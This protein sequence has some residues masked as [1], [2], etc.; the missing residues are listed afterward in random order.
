MNYTLPVIKT[1]LNSLLKTDIPPDSI[2]CCI[3]DS[4]SLEQKCSISEMLSVL[5]TDEYER[6]DSITNAAAK[7]RFILGRS[8]IRYALAYY[9]NK[10][11]QDIIFRYNAHGKPYQ[12]HDR[13][14]AFNLSH[15]ADQFALAISLIGE[16]GVDIEKHK[17]KRNI[18]GIANEILT[19][20]ELQW[21]NR[22]SKQEQAIQFYRLWSLKEATLKA[23]GVGLGVS[24]NSF[25]FG[26]SMA[27]CNWNHLFGSLALWRW[28]YLPENGFSI[29]VALKKAN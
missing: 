20:D 25:G 14:I 9:L 8:L 11:A 26:K 12:N 4:A 6:L 18:Q 5:S 16:V 10:P 21:F 15:T 19:A 7:K 29:A 1:D 22:L 28:S 17:L 2:L 24:A 27:V 23:E 13:I 3:T